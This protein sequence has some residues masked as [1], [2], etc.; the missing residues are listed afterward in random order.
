[1]RSENVPFMEENDESV[2]DKLIRKKMFRT[3]KIQAV[4]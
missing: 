2:K 4:I 1:M 3:K